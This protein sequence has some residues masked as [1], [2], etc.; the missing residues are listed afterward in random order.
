MLK[1]TKGRLLLTLLVITGLA[2]TLNDTALTGKERKTSM[3]LLKESKSDLYKSVKGLTEAQLNY[4]TAA[5]RWSVKECV[6]HIAGTEK[7]LGKLLDATMKA[8]ANPEKRAEIKVTDDQFVKMIESR[9]KKIKTS[10][11][12]EP[13][14]LGYTSI[15]HAL[16]DFKTE[17]TAHIKYVKVTTEDLRNHVAQL[18][19]G[20]IDCYQL[21]LMLG[22]HSVR[23]TKQ[24]KEV[25]DDPNFPKK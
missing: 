14:N 17:R 23:H 4:K 2:G 20:W 16:D 6:Y 9:D 13:Q 11:M 24:I 5:D 3:N 12:L 1:R 22:A 19:F 7:M 8:P 21:T 18:P 25:K 10:E 15:D